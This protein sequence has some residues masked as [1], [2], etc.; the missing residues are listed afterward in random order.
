MTHMDTSRPQCSDICA[1]F[2]LL[3]QSGIRLT[4]CLAQIHVK[5]KAASQ[6]ET[7]RLKFC[8]SCSNLVPR[9]PTPTYLHV[10]SSCGSMCL[11]KPTS[12]YNYLLHYNL[13]N[14]HLISTNTSQTVIK[15]ESLETFVFHSLQFGWEE[16]SIKILSAPR[17]S[18]EG[19]FFHLK[20]EGKL[21]DCFKS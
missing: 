9:N 21:S 8:T 12:V 20:I 14:W 16:S 1:P 7:L 11:A 18:P 3:T 10:V 19:F 13:R 6:H 2:P 5:T 17:F 15:T 4:M